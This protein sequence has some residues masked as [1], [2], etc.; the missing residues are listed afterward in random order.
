MV[1]VLPTPFTPTK[2]Q[3]LVTLASKAEADLAGALERR[4]QG[5]AQRGDDGVG[6]AELAALAPAAAGRR[7]GPWWW[8]RP[9]SARSRASSRSSQVCVV[10]R[11]RDRAAPGRSPRRGPGSCP[12]RS[13]GDRPGRR[14]RPRPPGPRRRAAAVGGRA[15]APSARGAVGAARWPGRR[16]A[17]RRAGGGCGRAAAGGAAAVAASGGG[18][19][20]RPRT[21][22]A[23]RRDEH[24]PRP[25]TSAAT[26]TTARTIQRAS[27]ARAA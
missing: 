22:A 17:G 16:S 26:T 10:D 11:A 9:T 4:A 15:R 3:T 13:R 20:E 18:G 24:R 5:V 7:A 19:C 8:P 2:S 12:C 25:T 14:P 6:A 21:A 1:V 23:R 27:M